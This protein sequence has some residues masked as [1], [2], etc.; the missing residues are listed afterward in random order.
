MPPLAKIQYLVQTKVLIEEL[1]FVNQQAGIARPFVHCLDDLVER[2]D[3][4]FEVWRVNAQRQKSA[5]QSAGHGDRK[6]REGRWIELLI[7]DHDRTIV[8]TDR[9]PVRQQRVLVGDVRVSVK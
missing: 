4:I 6:V 3:F 7:G 2:N 9:S 1:P 8:V 5:G